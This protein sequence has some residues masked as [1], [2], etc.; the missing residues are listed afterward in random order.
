MEQNENLQNTFKISLNNDLIKIEMTKGVNNV[1]DNV[2]QAEL[3]SQGLQEILKNNQNQKFNCL[4]DLTLLGL[5]AHYPSPQA[6]QIFAKMLDY[7]QIKKVAVL[8]PNSLLQSIM[9][10]IVTISR[11]KERIESFHNQSD[12]LKWLAETKTD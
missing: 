1:T 4:V 9:R 6:R 3:I 2:K 7:E 11:K 5:S 8:V 10:F 12:A